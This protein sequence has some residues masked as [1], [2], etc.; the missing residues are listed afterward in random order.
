MDKLKRQ[1]KEAKEKKKMEKLLAK[2]PNNSSSIGDQS[3][4]TMAKDKCIE[5]NDDDLFTVKS[6]PSGGVID[7]QV[8]EKT[9]TRGST[10]PAV[11][12]SKKKKEAK[13]LKI[14]SDGRVKLS[15]S[16]TTSN[17]GGVSKK[18][19][20]D[21]E[22]NPSEEQSM[23]LVHMPSSA[24][25]SV[26]DKERIAAHTLQVME[27]IAQTRPADALREKNRVRERRLAFKQAVRGQAAKATEDEDGGGQATLWNAD[28]EDMDDADDY[29][30]DDASDGAVM[31]SYDS[32][33][34]PEY[35]SAANKRVKRSRKQPSIEQDTV[36]DDDGPSE[37]QSRKKKKIKVSRSSPV[38]DDTDELSYSKALD[39]DDI[40]SQEALALRLINR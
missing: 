36:L 19:S 2:Q 24:A 13:L 39:L 29:P 25:G 33:R 27:R 40:R 4:S 38:D 11:T 23:Q 21:E 35:D 6:A 10:T 7:E 32:S 5:D 3:S 17:S 12:A 9:A 30:S 8:V 20:F 1:I 26:I 34:I 28:E 37:K 16:T 18:V 31:R 22:G 15:V 14:K